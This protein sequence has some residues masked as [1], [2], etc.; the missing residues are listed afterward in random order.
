MIVHQ[1]YPSKANLVLKPYLIQVRM[2][3]YLHKILTTKN[4]KI[5]L[6]ILV[7]QCLIQLYQVHLQ[8]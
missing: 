5:Y 6:M 7:G 8:Q 4:K 2:L 1:H 3:K